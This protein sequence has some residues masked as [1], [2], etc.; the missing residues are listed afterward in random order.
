MNATWEARAAAL[1][2]QIAQAV[3]A[4][5]ERTRLT[6]KLLEFTFK[7]SNDNAAEM[8]FVVSP[9][10]LIFSAG[11]GARFELDALPA[12]ENRVLELA[13]AIA[14][15]GLEERLWPGRVKFELRLQDGTVVTGGST[16]SL[17]PRPGKSRA[18]RY[19]SYD[20]V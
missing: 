4:E 11:P 3:S 8:G 16:S 1:A 9:H 15:G 2:E 10:E 12:S 13:L 19:A 20:R 6:S 17:I 14:G 7:P 18:V 5:S